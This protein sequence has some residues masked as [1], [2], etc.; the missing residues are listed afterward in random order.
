MFKIIRKEIDNDMTMIGPIIDFLDVETIGG[1]MY[2]YF[3]IEEG[4]EKQDEDWKRIHFKMIQVGSPFDEKDMDGYL[5]K[6]V[7]DKAGDFSD[8]F[9]SFFSNEI[10][11]LTHLVFYKISNIEEKKVDNISDCKTTK[12]FKPKQSSKINPDILKDFLK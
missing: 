7:Y 6:G 8:L 10:Q 5:Y 11:E 3:V 4:R 9:G 1:K 12:Q 2:G